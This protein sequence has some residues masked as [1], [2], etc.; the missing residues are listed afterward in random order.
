MS[1]TILDV[2]QWENAE[3]GDLIVISK[4]RDNT[5]CMVTDKTDT[6][7]RLQVRDHR[8]ISIKLVE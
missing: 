5:L 2:L 6:E 8:Y 1:T 4:G 7:I 3:L